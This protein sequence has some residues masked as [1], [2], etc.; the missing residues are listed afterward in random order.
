MPAARRRD[1]VTR[2]AMAP[3]AA[4]SSR[5][6]SPSFASKHLQNARFLFERLCHDGNAA[7]A[8]IAHRGRQIVDSLQ[9]EAALRRSAHACRPKGGPR[10]PGQ[11]EADAESLR[12]VF[13]RVATAVSD[14]RVP[15]PPV[16]S[17]DA[18]APVAEEVQVQAWDDFLLSLG[19]SS[20]TVTP[21]TNSSSVEPPG[22]L[23]QQTDWEM[24]SKEALG[25]PSFGDFGSLL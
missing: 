22:E 2:H 24:F 10:S 14:V 13:K 19:V 16:A 21:T 18:Q 25:D 3:D 9:K 15:P 11:L 17:W 23:L 6:S 4:V 8:E 12:A 20:E 7:I 5:P 1:S